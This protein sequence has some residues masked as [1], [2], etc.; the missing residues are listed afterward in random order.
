MT[1]AQ[2]LGPAAGAPAGPFAGGTGSAYCD[3]GLIVA[4]VTGPADPFFDK[5]TRFLGAAERG[6]VRPAASSPGVSEA[7]YVILG[8]AKAGRRRIVGDVNF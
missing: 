6:G 1:A 3:T 2:E 5:V 7:A 4:A 8:R